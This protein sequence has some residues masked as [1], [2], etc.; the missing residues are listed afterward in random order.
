MYTF[1][2]KSVQKVYK[3]CTSYDI[4]YPQGS[5][6]YQK[7]CTKVYKSVHQ[8][9]YIYGERKKFPRVQKH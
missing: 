9:I 4:Y 1:K 8:K 3:K 2:K 5:K 7:K 6:Y